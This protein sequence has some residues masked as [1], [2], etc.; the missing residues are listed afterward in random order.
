MIHWY[1][2]LRTVTNLLVAQRLENP[3]LTERQVACQEAFCYWVTGIKGDKND[4]E[5]DVSM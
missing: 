4:D 2:I 5:E 3:S 1:A